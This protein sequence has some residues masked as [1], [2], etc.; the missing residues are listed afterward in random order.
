MKDKKTIKRDILD[1][2]REIDA[3]DSNQLPPHWL[4]LEY[5]RELKVEEKKIFKKAMQELMTAGIA[6]SVEGPSL[7]LRL[8]LKGENLIYAG[9][10]HKPV[11]EENSTPSGFH[12]TDTKG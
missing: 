7:N 3:E 10:L 12:F 9:G 1:K 8:T 4:K 6:E 2:F 11:R 5:L